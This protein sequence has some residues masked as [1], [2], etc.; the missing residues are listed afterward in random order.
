MKFVSTRNQNFA[1][2]FSEALKK[3]LAPDGGLFVPEKF[4][5]L[6]IQSLEALAL[7]ENSF[8]S[9]AA[10]VLR[11]FLAGDPLQEFLND[12][13]TS[14]LNFAIPLK[15]L[16]SH[17]AI[18]ELFHGPTGAFKDVGARFLAACMERL[19]QANKEKQTV[20]VATS[21][22]TGGAV[23]GAFFGKKDFE[24]F[25][26]FPQGKISARQEKQL[27]C[28]GGNVRA[29]AV[30]GTFDDCQKIVKT[31]LRDEELKAQR[32]FTSAN[33]ISI[34]RLLPQMI[35][36]AHSSLRYRQQ[37][38]RVAGFIVPTG[39]LGNALA[40]LWAKHLGFPIAKVVLATNANHAIVDYF[41][42]GQW[43]PH[44][45]M[46]TLA[47][48]MDVG[49]PS[50]MERLRHLYANLEEMKKEVAAFSVGDEQIK[51]SIRKGR[52]RWNE[53]LC[54][55]TATAAFTY[56]Q[57][58]QQNPS[59]DWILVATA[60]PAKFES[61][62]EPLIQQTIPIPPELAELLSRPSQMV[63]IPADF[64]A[65]KQAI[66]GLYSRII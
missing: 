32:Q 53:T 17:A 49:D 56:E 45:S 28:W 35:Y 6:D 52:Q 37:S 62:V 27:T 4:P 13:C 1:V 48:A 39:N 38:G 20:L 14:A 25:I 2:T 58:S 36:Y 61:V 63:K 11:P 31:A 29:F 18:L 21:G 41:A 59:Q 40:A 65:F 8:A 50:N 3:G 15:K 33:S 19:S 64:A 9:F 66:R 12:I 7:R 26:L 30:Q 43:R 54:P 24:V 47:N 5:V 22:D 57:L 16:E 10:E 34:G 46:T 51:D 42:S 23:A 55:H 60:H 44:S